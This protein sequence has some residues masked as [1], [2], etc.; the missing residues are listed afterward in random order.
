MKLG[1]TTHKMGLDTGAS[2]PHVHL[3]SALTLVGNG[4]A[5]WGTSTEATLADGTVRTQ[6]TITIN[7]V[8][9]GS[10]VADSVVA[11]VGDDDNGVELL[12]SSVLN[13]AGRFTIDA[14]AHLI[15]FG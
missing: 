12:G 5:T 7:H 2:T 9:I 3:S 4:E 8:S 10:L 14:Q 15:I 11:T 13:R 1:S 6:R